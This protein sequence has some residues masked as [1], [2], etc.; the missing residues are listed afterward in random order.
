MCLV[1]VVEI[2]VI[3]FT[4]LLLCVPVPMW[5]TLQGSFHLPL[6]TTLSVWLLFYPFCRWE[7]WGFKRWASI[8]IL[9]QK[10]ARLWRFYSSHGSHSHHSLGIC[11]FSS[12]SLLFLCGKSRERNISAQGRLHKAPKPLVWA[13]APRGAPRTSVLM[14]PLFLSP[15]LGFSWPMPFLHDVLLLISPFSVTGRDILQLSVPLTDV[16]G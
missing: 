13:P 6:L 4:E 8:R 10:E 7:D 16:Y 5:S 14:P 2:Q 15:S 3:A 11:D 9:A 1:I 12:Q